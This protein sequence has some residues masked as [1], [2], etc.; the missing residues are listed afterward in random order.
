[1]FGYFELV[2]L[3]VYFFPACSC[4]G[5]S[6]SCYF[7]RDLYEKTGHGG[8]CEDC[9]ENTD[10][11]HCERCMQYHYLHQTMDRCMPCGCN[12]LGEYQLVCACVH[13]FS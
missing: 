10:G 1:M 2:S 8:H 4:S 5:M 3:V 9:R 12:D 13:V 6:D 11:P 7:D